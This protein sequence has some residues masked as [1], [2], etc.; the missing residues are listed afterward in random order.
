M[1]FNYNFVRIYLVLE[2]KLSV[3]SMVISLDS[4]F[5]ENAEMV[6]EKQKQ[7]CEIN[8]FKRMAERIKKNY[9]KYKFIVVGDALYATTPIINICK[10]NKWQY[11]F[12][13]KTERLKES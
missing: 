13:L 2:C 9:P 8:A 10:K 4:E 5:I 6:T 11:I 3:G 12:N 1:T 7:D